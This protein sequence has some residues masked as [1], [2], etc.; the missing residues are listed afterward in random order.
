MVSLILY[1]DPKYPV[2]SAVFKTPLGLP[3]GRVIF[4]ERDRAA[5]DIALL[6]DGGA[7]LAAIEPPGNSTQVPIPGKL[8]M[9]EERQSESVAGNGCGLSRGGAARDHCGARRTA[10][11]GGHRHRRD[12]EADRVNRGSAKHL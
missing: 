5:T 10:H 9:L 2:S 11:V 3:D 12:S 4:A 6:G 8:K 1:S 7:V